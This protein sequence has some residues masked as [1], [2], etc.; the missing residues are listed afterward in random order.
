[1]SIVGLTHLHLLTEQFQTAEDRLLL[2][3]AVRHQF[4]IDDIESAKTAYQHLSVTTHADGALVIGALLQTILRAETSDEER[5]RAIRLFLRG[6]IRDT[7]FRHH[8]HRM[9]QILCQSYDTGAKQAVVHI[10]QLLPT[11]LRII[12][13]AARHRTL[14]DQFP[15]IFHHADGRW[16]SSSLS[17]HSGD[18]HIRHLAI[19][20]VD[21]RIIGGVTCYQPALL[22]PSHRC[23]EVLI[24]V[25]VI[26]APGLKLTRLA[27]Q[28]LNTITQRTDPDVAPLILSHRPDIVIQQTVV[29]TRDQIVFHTT[30]GINLD[31]TAIIG[32]KPKGTVA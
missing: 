25:C 26:R 1:M 8:P 4:R 7:V 29:G 2:I 27:V 18:C 6:D 22:D 12:H 11:R 30:V 32:T 20:G 23:H 10:Q 31:Q 15:T 28:S 14:P 19:Y 9:T 24:E 21:Q 13:T 17:W 5:P 3:T 16:R